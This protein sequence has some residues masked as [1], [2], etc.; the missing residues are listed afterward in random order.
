MQPKLLGAI[1]AGGRSRRFGSDKA[2]AE[3]DGRGLLDHAIDGLGAQTAALV[4]CGREMQG[5]TCLADRPEPGLGPL[6][7]VSAALHF[8]AAHDFEAVLTSAC[9]TPEVPSDLADILTGNGSSVLIGQP[10]FGYWPAWLSAELDNFLE[11]TDGRS[12]G[13]WA[14]CTDARRV[15]FPGDLPNI[16]T[17]SDL[18]ALRMKSLLGA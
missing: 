12:M 7:G 18:T 17:V 16:N 3:L 15:Y 2:L 11:G 4:I 14:A 8:A 1:I 6:G 5:Y 9:D 10:L 13:E